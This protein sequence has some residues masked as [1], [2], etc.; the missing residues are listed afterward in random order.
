MRVRYGE[1][2]AQG[3]VF[4]ARWGDYVDVAVTEYQRAMFG[5][6]HPADTGTDLKLV[7]QTL[8]WRAGAHFDDVLDCRI[9]TARIGTTSFTFTTRFRRL[10]DGA[11]LATAETVYVACDHRGAKQEIP[12]GY[13]ASLERGAAGIV[14]DH[15]GA[16]K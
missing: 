15:A 16:L 2:D 1:C 9:S 6:V 8:E 10:T 4:N 11:D 3:V 5:S 14:V 7:K 13:R 12:A